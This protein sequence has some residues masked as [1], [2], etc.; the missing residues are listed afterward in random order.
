MG[1]VPWGIVLTR[2]FAPHVDLRGSGS[3]NIGATN[4]R[5]TAGW[6]LGL[7]TLAA[8][9]G[10]GAIPVL[11]ARL[12]PLPDGS[13]ALVAA[14]AFLGHL[15]PIYTGLKGGGKGVAT[16][17]GCLMV[18]SPPALVVGLITFVAAAAVFRRVSAASLA[19]VA[20]MPPA[21]WGFGA[22]P[23]MMVWAVATAGLVWIRHRENIQRLLRG[24][25]PRI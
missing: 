3:G 9:A 11:L 13:V 8:D 22:S 5:R 19:S 12:A 2:H 18:I 14:S 4:V 1:S 23:L 16:V 21:L 17:G 10:K 7:A 25:E 15:Y 20:V 6:Q 24:T